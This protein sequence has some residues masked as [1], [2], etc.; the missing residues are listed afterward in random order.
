MSGGMVVSTVWCS[1]IRKWL[2][3]KREETVEDEP[4]VEEYR[5]METRGRA[6]RSLRLFHH[7]LFGRELLIVG[8]II[9]CR[10]SIPEKLCQN[11]RLLP[12]SNN[13]EC[14]FFFGAN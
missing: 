6:L 3:L 7:T 9:L 8:Q 13:Y 5:W 11:L 14:S 1:V 10:T 12:V 2:N 4:E